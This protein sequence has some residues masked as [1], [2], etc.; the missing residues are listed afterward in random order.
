MSLQARLKQT[1]QTQFPE[2]AVR[3][4][5][6]SNLF[7]D[8]KEGSHYS[9]E[10]LLTP[11]NADY[12]IVT[13]FLGFAPSLLGQTRAE[14]FLNFVAYENFGLRGCSIL[15]ATE[16]RSLLL[17]SS[18]LA[19][20]TGGRNEEESLAMDLINLPAHA[21]RLEERLGRCEEDGHFSLFQYLREFYQKELTSLKLAHSS[22]KIFEG[23]TVEAFETVERIFTQELRYPFERINFKAARVKIP[24]IN[25]ET[26]LKI[27]E[28][29][30]MLT[31]WT[32]MVQWPAS[33]AKAYE[34]T[35]HL[36]LQT[37]I[38]H[39]EILSRGDTIAHTAFKP[40]THTLTRDHIEL[41]VGSIVTARILAEKSL[42][43]FL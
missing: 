32:P 38:G 11:I 29:C 8:W 12:S 33:F 41:L 4:K 13:S 10:L 9:V 26:I 24:G 34:F 7:V 25:L 40:L 1:I 27:P 18:F 21:S 3:E 39:F 43:D 28:D 16:Q 36:N 17:K 15:G 5:D 20:P 2:A 19:G 35:N 14:D 31:L 37:H 23:D 6:D 42:P 30:P 22:G